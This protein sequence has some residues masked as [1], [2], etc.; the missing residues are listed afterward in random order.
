MYEEA[1]ETR[2]RE[3]QMFHDAMHEIDVLMLPTTPCPAIKLHDVD[4][5]RTASIL[6]RFVNQLGLCAIALPCGFTRSPATSD[7]ETSHSASS[8]EGDHAQPFEL[9]EAMPLSVQFVSQAFNETAIVRAARSLELA[10]SLKMTP[11]LIHT[12]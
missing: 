2:R 11:P 4:E 12:R 8:H 3:S 6:T 5:S 1:L 7:A 9:G 10:L